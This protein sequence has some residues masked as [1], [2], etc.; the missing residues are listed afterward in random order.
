MTALKTYYDDYRTWPSEWDVQGGSQLSIAVIE[1][2]EGTNTNLNPRSFQYLGSG[3]DDHKGTLLDPWG[4][5]YYFAIDGNND[6][7]LSVGSYPVQRR[8]V[9]WSLGKNKV[10]EFG[11][12]DDITTWK[13]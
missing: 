13:N 2:L 9:V 12:G 8:V 6:N 4:S 10:N 7:Q 3:H 11:Q 5:P 1:A